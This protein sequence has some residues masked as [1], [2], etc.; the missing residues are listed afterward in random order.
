MRFTALSDLYQPH[1]DPPIWHLAI[2]LHDDRDTATLRYHPASRVQW[3]EQSGERTPL[4]GRPYSLR[5]SVYVW[6]G[7]AEFAGHKLRISYSK[8]FFIGKMYG[9]DWTF[10]LRG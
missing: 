3:P 2:L 6:W 7:K 1:H 8:H 5:L 4:L 10:F 9:I